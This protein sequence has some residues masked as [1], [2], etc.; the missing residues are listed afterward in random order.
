VEGR[1]RKEQGQKEER[2]R[3]EDKEGRSG[4]NVL[5]VAMDG[6]WG[7]GARAE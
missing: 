7:K 2:K 1:W 5:V 6:N 4:K 3:K